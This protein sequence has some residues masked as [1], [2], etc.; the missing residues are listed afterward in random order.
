MQDSPEMDAA[1]NPAAWH[2]FGVA[3]VGASAALLGL[4]FVVVSLHL[5]AVVDDPVVR[6]R[7]EITLGLFATALAAS[8][9]LLIPGQSR[10]ALGIELMVIALIYI[11]LST[12]ATFHATHSARGVSRDRLARFVLGELSACL[13]FVGGLGLLVH[14][15]GGAYLVAAGVVLGVLSAMLAIWMLFVGL[16]IEQLER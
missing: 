3:L 11:S 8:A 7:A 1:Y 14:A 9:A 6:R 12:L 15:L 16:G 2:D 13:I 5:A 10:E 4:V